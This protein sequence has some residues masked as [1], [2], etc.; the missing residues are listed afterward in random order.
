MQNHKVLYCRGVPDIQAL[1]GVF[2]RDFP[3]IQADKGL[4]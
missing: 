4:V 2:C 3:D 1:K